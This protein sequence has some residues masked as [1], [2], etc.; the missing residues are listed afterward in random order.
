MKILHA[1]LD[2]A[3]VGW[4][5]TQALRAAGYEADLATI[6]SSKFTNAGNIDLSFSGEGK[7]ARQKKKY[8]F[9]TKVLPGYDV[10]HYHAGRSILDYGDGVFSLMDLRA[11]RERGQVV[12]MTYHGCE[13]RGVHP[14]MCHSYCTD[15]V[16]ENQ[17]QKIR[18]GELRDLVDIFYVTTPDLL[19]SAPYATLMPQSVWG[20][21]E[22][23]VVP[24]VLVGNIRIAHAPSKRSTKGSE[25]VIAACEELI[26]EGLPIEFVLIEGMEHQAALKEMSTVDIVVD[27]IIMGWYCVV[28]I[29]AA[30]RG[31]V[32][33]TSID[34]NIAQRTLSIKP[35][36]VSASPK[37]IKEV[38]R[39]LCTTREEFST[40]G[41]EN[42]R[43]ALE[44]HNALEHAKIL[45]ADYQKV[46]EEKDHV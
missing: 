39:K 46:R 25:H 43:Y 37:T 32:V 10:V 36:F 42:R 28:A 1:P 5:L 38:L 6:S 9:C 41:K 3:G 8:D 19:S 31:K 22:V 33:V 21:K 20:M 24:P 26:L 35:P 29:E 18:I 4:S 17:K 34:A 14:E 13:L 23:E 15:K 7:I 44:T 12:A 11:A 16:C 30:V 40:M 45:L 27:N 2:L